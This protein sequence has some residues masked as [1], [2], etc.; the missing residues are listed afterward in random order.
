ML[1]TAEEKRDLIR[2]VGESLYDLYK[3]KVLNLL[4]TYDLS[5]IHD[6]T[7]LKTVI[8][9]FFIQPYYDMLEYRESLE[10]DSVERIN[11]DNTYPNL[12]HEAVEV[13]SRVSGFIRDYIEKNVQAKAQKDM[14][15]RMYVDKEK[16]AN[17]QA[18]IKQLGR[19][20]FGKK[21]DSTKI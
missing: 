9:E 8:L 4:P 6:D 1:N 18:Q 14:L 16:A 17:I 11:F 13:S 19:S 7:S 3:R 20:D 12:I 10:E 15:Y 2:Y 5:V 21:N